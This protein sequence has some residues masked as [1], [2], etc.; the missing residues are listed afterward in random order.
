MMNQDPVSLYPNQ[1]KQHPAF[2]KT[3]TVRF[4]F[5]EEDP[6]YANH[7][8]GFA[9]VPGSLIMEAFLQT[10]EKN[11][12][13]SLPLMVKRFQFKRFTRPRQAEAKI[14]RQ[15]DQWHCELFQEGVLTAKGV[16]SKE[17]KK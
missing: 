13:E 17:D 14:T 5:S 4:T 12:K 3:L 10:I 16:I 11:E 15:K 7:F 8:Q 9:V 6:F 2:S 1:K